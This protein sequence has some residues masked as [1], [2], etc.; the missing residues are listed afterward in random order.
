MQTV[1][2]FHNQYNAFFGVNTN[3]ST[4]TEND[5]ILRSFTD[6]PQIPLQQI[7][8]YYLIM[9]DGAMDDGF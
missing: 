6:D 2:D 1:D 3:S 9:K 4:H 8:V 5:L 7:K